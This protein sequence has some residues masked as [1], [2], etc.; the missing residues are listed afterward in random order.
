VGLND[1]WRFGR[2]LP[3]GHFAP[4]KDGVFRLDFHHRSMKT[5]MIYL[6]GATSM[7]PSSPSEFEGGSTNLIYEG[8]KFVSDETGIYHSLEEFIYHKI[9]PV[10]GMALVFNHHMMHEGERVK[11]G[12]KYIMRSDVMFRRVPQISEFSASQEQAICWALKAAEL[13]TDKK[14]QEATDAY[15]R[16]EKLWPEVLRTNW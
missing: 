14:G 16:A 11:A 4:H 9:R 6:N 3:G 5:F 13:E 7:D 2:Y 10:A 12:K 8:S 15:K 1:L